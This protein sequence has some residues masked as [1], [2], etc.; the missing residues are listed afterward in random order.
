MELIINTLSEIICSIKIDN[1]SDIAK[2]IYDG[3][4]PNIDHGI[5]FIVSIEKEDGTVILNNYLLD[6]ELAM[7]CWFF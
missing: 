5:T 3:I 1:L 2:Q 7:H 4:I 6:D